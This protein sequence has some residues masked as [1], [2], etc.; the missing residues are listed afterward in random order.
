MFSGGVLAQRLLHY[1]KSGM[2]AHIL[3]LSTQKVEEEG[4][5]DHIQ[6][7]SEFKATLVHMRLY[8][9]TTNKLK[10]TFI[11]PVAFNCQ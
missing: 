9:I 8:N 10:Q 2:V 3:D 4:S 5:K 6:L 11:S 7:H 1:I